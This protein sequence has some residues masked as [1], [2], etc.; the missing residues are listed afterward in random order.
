MSGFSDAFYRENTLKYV[1]KLLGVTTGQDDEVIS[2]AVDDGAVGGGDDD[3]ADG[4][5]DEDDIGGGDDDGREHCGDHYSSPG[6]GSEDDAD[7]QGQGRCEGLR[8]SRPADGVE[9]RERAEFWFQP[10]EVR[11]VLLS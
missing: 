7:N 2:D 3:D 5:R 6:G 8:L 9:T 11:E 10:S 1:G 4:G